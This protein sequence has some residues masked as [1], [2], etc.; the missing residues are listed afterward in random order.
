MA[1]ILIFHDKPDYEELLSKKGHKI[2]TF[3]DKGPALQCAQMH[4]WDLALVNT[5]LPMGPEILQGLSQASPEIRLLAVMGAPS[6]PRL[7][8][9]LSLG[10]QEILFTPLDT[11]ELESKVA[12]VAKATKRNLKEAL[13]L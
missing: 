13:A 8:E 4:K 7:R 12:K 2:M 10:V 5:Q 1:N 3:S 11:A 6:L 9:A